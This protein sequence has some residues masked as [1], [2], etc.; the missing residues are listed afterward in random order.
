MLFKR[1]TRM[2]PNFTNIIE[3]LMTESSSNN[4]KNGLLVRVRKPVLFMVKGLR[5][6]I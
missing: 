4:Q 2:I 1:M 3:I 5:L 6:N